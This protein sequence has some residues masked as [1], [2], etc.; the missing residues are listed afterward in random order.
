[1]A[2]DIFAKLSNPIPPAKVSWRVGN[3]N[4][5]AEERRTN[6]K[7]AKATKGQALAYLDARDVM[8]RLDEVCG[9]DKWEDSYVETPKGRLICTIAIK[10][11]DEWVRKSDGAGDTQVEGEKGAISDAFKRAGVKWG[12]GRYLYDI[13]SPWIALDERGG[14]A[15]HDY[16]KLQALLPGSKVFECEPAEQDHGGAGHNPSSAPPPKT[17]GAP[18]RPAEV[19][20]FFAKTRLLIPV[21]LSEDG[22]RSDW[23]GWQNK[24]A[25][26]LESAITPEEVN[27]LWSDNGVPYSNAPEDVKKTLA[28]KHEQRLA[29]FSQAPLDKVA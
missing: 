16:A 10:V 4:K 27:K 8:N 11:G 12:I 6:D 25:G 13:E 3:T 24:V 9:P 5:K 29:F 19:A 21:P 23:S 18:T 17:G 22:E 26:A 7:N 1:M 2:E 15:K 28:R 20:K 14:I